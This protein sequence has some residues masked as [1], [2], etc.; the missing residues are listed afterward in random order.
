MRFFG[1]VHWVLP[2]LVLVIGMYS[3]IRFV[4]GYLNEGTFT[5]TDRRL[6][7]VF[8]GLLDLQ[9]TVGLI[10]F[11]GTGFAGIG[12]P[13]YRILHAVVM[14]AAAVIP[15]FSIVWRNADDKTLFL[16]NFYILLASFLLM[17]VG[18]SLIP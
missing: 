3:I 14:F 15:H 1:S 6:M 11:F 4:R 13:T 17:L 7:A 16:N 9:G 8:T 10:F 5:K 18:L 12:F 2:W